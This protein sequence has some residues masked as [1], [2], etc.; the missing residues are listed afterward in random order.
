MASESETVRA[1]FEAW[2][3]EICC[4]RK[5]DGTIYYSK[6]V[7]DMWAVWQAARSRTPSA[8]AKAMTDHIRTQFE[9]WWGPQCE[10]RNALARNQHGGYVYPGSQSAW[11]LWQAVRHQLLSL[12]GPAPASE[13]RWSCGGTATEAAIDATLAAIAQQPKAGV[14]AGFDHADMDAAVD[15]HAAAAR[16]DA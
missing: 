6:R 16:G 12:D 13:L 5:L 7:T 14:Y 3:A 2:V 8:E 9:A 4:A 10:I 11:D 15:A 1:E